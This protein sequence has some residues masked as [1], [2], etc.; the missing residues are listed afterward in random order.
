MRI[1]ETQLRRIIK[2]SIKKVLNENTNDLP[3][4]SDDDIHK[5]YEGFKISEFS[6]KPR[7]RNFSDEYTWDISFMIIFPNAEHPDF[8]E[9]LWENVFVYDEK[10]EEIAFDH[11]Y[12]DDI[13]KQLIGFIRR[14]IKKHW[15]EME[16]IKRTPSNED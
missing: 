4:L 2:E 14:E 15:P 11:W 9:S 1:N 3:Y 5:Q 10:G 8:D 6:I 12:P 13:A 16:A 7:R